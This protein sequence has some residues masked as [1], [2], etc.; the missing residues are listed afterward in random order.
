MPAE[1]PRSTRKSEEMFVRLLAALYIAVSLS[2]AGFKKCCPKGEAVQYELFEDNNL[3]PRK[4]FSCTKEP[5]TRIRIKSKNK[6]ESEGY[7]IDNSTSLNEMM[8]YNVL[9]DGNSHWPSCSDASSLSSSIIRDTLRV[10]QSG[11]CVDIM[12]GIFHIFICDEG[13]ETANDFKELYTFRKCCE[14]DFTYDI[15]GRQCAFSNR[16]F[17]ARDAFEFFGDKSVTFTAGLPVCK[18][19]DVLVEYHELVHKLK[20]YESS[21]VITKTNSHGPD[22]LLHNSFCIESTTNSLANLPDGDDNQHNKNASKWIAKV[23]R[24]KEICNEMP[25]I[26]KCCKEGLRIVYEN[27]TS[28][29]E[30][31][32]FHLDIHFHNFD[33]EKSPEKPDALEPTGKS[34]MIS[35]VKT[36]I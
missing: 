8:A 32:D 15:Y 10:S 25:C 34:L 30:P 23:C 27:E 33:F 26:R 9:I 24:P 12:D 4:H 1:W 3:S 21:L 14:K 7:W 19:D 28:F 20:I 6:R 35:I 22:L 36:N 5:V 16:T 31:H 13:L 18:P 2:E 17:V 29:C 11:S